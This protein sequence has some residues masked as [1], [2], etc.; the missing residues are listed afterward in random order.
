[1]AS[2]VG[3]RIVRMIAVIDIIGF[4]LYSLVGLL[5]GGVMAIIIHRYPLENVPLL[6]ALRCIRSN[7]PINVGDWLPIIGYIRQRGVCRH[8]HKPLP[9]RFLIIEIITALCFGLTYASFGL[10]LRSVIF[11]VFEA[12]LIVIGAI[13]YRHRLIFPFMI[14]VGVALAFAWSIFDDNTAESLIPGSNPLGSLG[15]ALIGG[16]MFL[17]IYGVGRAMFG[18]A[19]LGR[20][21]IYLAVL[22][23]AICGARLTVPTL[24]LGS[25]LGSLFA[26]TVLVFRRGGMKTFVPFGTWMA[27]AAILSLIFG[28]KLWRD[29][30]LQILGG[31][32]DLM[33]TI[34]VK[35]IERWL[36]GG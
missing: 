24:F 21:D 7:E 19:A 20:G 2:F 29:G 14:Y 8:C 25:I 28:E 26:L 35:I 13:D 9:R 12:L 16:L 32:L 3:Q 4:V 6:G 27:A 18:L 17:L 33:F 30:P 5:L 23:G 11:C 1:M 34:T 10:G 15:G 31:L 36:N 22:I